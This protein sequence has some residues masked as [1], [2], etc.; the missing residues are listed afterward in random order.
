MGVRS[1]MTFVDLLALLPIIAFGLS[2]LVLALGPA[3]ERANRA[4]CRSFLKSMGCALMSYATDWKGRLPQA[5]YDPNT[6]TAMG[7]DN[8]GHDA[9]KLPPGHPNNVSAAMYL[10]LK[11]CDLSAEVFRCPSTDQV[12]FDYHGKG[13]D[14]CSNFG[15][16]SNVGYSFTNPYP[17]ASGGVKCGYEW[18]TKGPERFAIAADR[19]D[20]SRDLRIHA[21]SPWEQQRTLNSHNHAQE[22]QNVLYRDGHAEWHRTAW[23]GADGD[24]IYT[25]ARAKTGSWPPAQDDPAASAEGFPE[26][27]LALDTVLVPVFP[28]PQ[29]AISTMLPGAVVVAIVT[30]VVAGVMVVGVWVVRRR[31]NAGVRAHA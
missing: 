7:F 25:R 29:E 31:R 16:P 10:L 28:A 1:G 23:A 15:E 13:A 18:N 17:M 19:N 12:K 27:A 24:N 5:E 8:A 6:V 14:D 30:G 3:R 20:G 4:L 22:G 26:P 9:A 21:Q 2:L 11:T